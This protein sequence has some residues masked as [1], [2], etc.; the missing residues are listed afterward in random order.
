V[1]LLAAI[2]GCCMIVQPAN[3]QQKSS[4]EAIAERRFEIAWCVEGA[5]FRAA[6]PVAA[7]PAG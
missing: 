7:I 1:K 4:A 2:L 6:T 3:A 5:Y